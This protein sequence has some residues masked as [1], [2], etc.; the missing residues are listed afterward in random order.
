MIQHSKV[1]ELAAS[2]GHTRQQAIARGC[3]T[4]RLPLSFS[5]N[6]WVCSPVS[7]T[8]WLESAVES[9]CLWQTSVSCQCVRMTMIVAII[10][11]VSP[12]LEPKT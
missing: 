3:R 4:P 2:G 9:M 12:S 8:P 10:P 1:S 5:D 11:L 6:N 7:E